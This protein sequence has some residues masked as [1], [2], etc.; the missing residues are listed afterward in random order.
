MAHR[1]F[2]D[3]AGRVWQAWDVMP[4]RLDRRV[5]SDRRASPES[6]ARGQVDRPDAANRRHRQRRS[7]N[8]RRAIPRHLA[9]LP[10]T[11]ADGW[12]CFECV[13]EKRRLVPVPPAWD[14]LSDEELARL[15]ENA[16]VA[17]AR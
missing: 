4:E 7:R 10:R 8:D 11:H 1:S 5:T 14:R 3:A 2:I 16:S 12:L 17:R 13:E 15:L 9:R 6:D